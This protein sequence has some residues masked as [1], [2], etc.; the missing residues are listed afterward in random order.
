M[1]TKPHNRQPWTVTAQRLVLADIRTDATSEIFLPC[2]DRS[3]KAAF[4]ASLSKL[5]LSTFPIPELWILLWPVLPFYVAYWF[6]Q[7]HRPQPGWLIEIQKRSLQA[8][9]QKQPKS[10]L[11]TP[12]MGLLAHHRQIDITHPTQGP[13]LILFTAAP[14]SDPQDA[15]A[16]ENLAN[17]LAEQL[18]LRLV[19]CRVA[20]N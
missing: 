17:T 8:V 11:L 19:G 3:S 9:R 20:L 14:S 6:W 5:F 12:E 13:I 15:I 7:R 4:R 1:T 10:Y 16:L 2:Q 18:Q